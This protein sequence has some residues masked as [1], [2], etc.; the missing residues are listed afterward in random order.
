MTDKKDT[1]EITMTEY[2][3]LQ[4]KAELWDFYGSIGDIEVDNETY[5]EDRDVYTSDPEAEVI[6][7]TNRTVREETDFLSQC[8][9]DDECCEEVINPCEGCTECAGCCEKKEENDG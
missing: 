1:I 7:Y 6:L 3:M 9:P 4:A 8:N 2:T 5:D